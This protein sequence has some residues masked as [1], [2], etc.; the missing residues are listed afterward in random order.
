MNLAYQLLLTVLFCVASAL[1]AGA[2]DPRPACSNRDPLRRPFFGDLHVHTTLSLDASTQGTKLR[3]R[4]A[5]AFAQGSEVGIQPHDENGNALRTLRLKRPLD[6]AAVTDHA[7]LFGELRICRTPGLPGHDSPICMV[8]RRWPRLAFFMMNSRSAEGAD[9][10]RFSFCGENDENCLSAAATPWKE[11]IDAAEE[12]YDRSEECSFTSFIAYEWTGAPFASN[13]HRNVIFRNTDVPA[14]PVSSLDATVVSQLWRDLDAKCTH[15]RKNCEVL[16]IPHNSNLSGG[17]MFGDEEETGQPFTA[18]Y[19]RLRKRSEPLAELI[20]HKGDSECRMGVGTSD[21]LC[22]F[23]L[24]PY[25]TFAGKFTGLGSDD[26][27]PT[28]FVRNALKDGL[29]LEERFGTNPYQFGLIGSTDTH[30]GTPGYIDETAHPGHGGAGTPAKEGGPK[31]LPDDIEFNPGGLAVLWAEENNRDSLFDAM[32]RRETYSTSGPRMAV[33][34]FGGWGYDAG[35]CDAG[36]FAAQG[37]AGGVPMGGELPTPVG[38]TARPTFA[39][40]AL[41]DPGTPEAPPVALERI[42]IVKGWTKDGATHERVYDVAR[43]AAGG[44]SVDPL[45][46]ERSGTGPSALCAVWTDPDFDPGDRAFYYARVLQGPTCRWHTWTC[47][48]AGVL[49]DDPTT[50][51]NELE[52]CCDESYPRTIQER[53]VTSPIWYSP[54]S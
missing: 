25:G 34:F 30:L 12:A 22:N 26:P 17:L 35:L 50:V 1:S 4:D 8:Y 18:E 41:A 21:E 24:L 9:A 43:D 19:V 42:Q 48:A 27:D 23:E 28:N 53:A 10:T 5:Y 3:P 47:N 46:C 37:Y 54:R 31:R 15:G 52:P 7:E 29:L 39:V 32:R 33:R 20:Q 2:A 11:T 38:S 49:C 44:G 40:A 14:L 6:F 13:L 51:T 36:D 16:A 45:T